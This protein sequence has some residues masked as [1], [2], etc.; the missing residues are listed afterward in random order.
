MAKDFNI[1]QWRRNHLNE[2]HNN[3]SLKAAMEEW[4]GGSTPTREEMINFVEWFYNQDAS[5]PSMMGLNEMGE[6]MVSTLT[7]DD[8]KGKKVPYD[9]TGG[10][11]IET[12]RPGA[13]E[14]WKE[15]FIRV[16]GDAKLSINGDKFIPSNKKIDTLNKTAA[17]D[18]RGAVGTVD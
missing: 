7:F 6:M 8:V 11:W 15:R 9:I 2:G 5:E 1:Y 4:F 12:L 10:A 13:F 16:Y 14:D 3:P 17:S 18:I